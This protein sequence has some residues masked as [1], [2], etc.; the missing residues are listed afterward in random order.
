LLIENEF[1]VAAPADVTWAFL[2][3]VERVAA[4]AP[5][6]ELTDVVDDR[7]WK[8]RVAVKVGPVAM[9]FAGTVAIQERDDEAR[10]VVLAAKGQETKGK[11]AASAV[12]TSW[13]EERAGGSLVKM[14]ADITLSGTVAQLSRGLLPDVSRRLTAEFAECLRSILAREP[15]TVTAGSA[16]TP[17]TAPPRSIGGVR[18]GLWAAWRSLVRFVRR[19][20][21]RW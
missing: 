10:R 20:L 3:D 16:A 17:A 7:T 1:E 12:V 5:G 2:L 14:R 11:G 18:L 6:A 13:L 4:C 21:G 9:A 15:E 19:L 8:G